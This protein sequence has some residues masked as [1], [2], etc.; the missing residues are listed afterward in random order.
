M[1]RGARIGCAVGLVPL[2]LLLGIVCELLGFQWLPATMIHL[3][4]GWAAHAASTLPRVHVNWSGVGMLAAC[5][6][7]SAWIGHRFLAWL[8]SGT[9][10]VEPWRPRWTLAGLALIVLMFA[11]GMSFTAVAHQAGW[12]LRSPEPLVSSGVATGGVT[13]SLKSI[14]MAQSDFQSIDRD[15]NP[16]HGFWRSD[17]AGLYA[18]PGKDGQPVKL[19]DIG[20]AAA[21]DRPTTEI[22]KYANS[23][24]RYGYWFRALRCKE[25]AGRMDAS[26]RFAVCAFPANASSGRYMFLITEQRTLF[27]KECPDAKP[28]DFCPDDPAQ[29][30]WTKL[31]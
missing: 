22:R 3:G 9:G 14:A 28:P 20:I 5:I 1:T 11:A 15:S 18:L 21:D 4:F 8:W 6:A 12:L 23:S 10:H 24:P 29:D 25:D 26:T 17:V 27:R 16:L 19:L 2:F 7:L 13:A 30:G 31:D